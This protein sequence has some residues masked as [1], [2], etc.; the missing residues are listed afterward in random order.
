MTEG[1][2][3]DINPKIQSSNCKYQ[4]LNCTLIKDVQH[5]LN[6]Y[7]IVPTNIEGPQCFFGALAVLSES[8]NFSLL[9]HCN[10]LVFNVFFC[11]PDS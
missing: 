3:N 2:N 1:G 9:L 8:Y 6:A 7:K 10:F 11:V 5:L 4:Y